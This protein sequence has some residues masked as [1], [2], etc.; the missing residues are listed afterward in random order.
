MKVRDRDEMQIEWER[1]GAGEKS[2]SK[3]SSWERRVLKAYA[4]LFAR[5]FDLQSPYGVVAASLTGLGDGDRPA[6]GDAVSCSPTTTNHSFI[7][8]PKICVHNQ[9]KI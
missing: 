3:V 4:R 6:D 7:Q 2:E 8:A 9:V 1:E 5:N